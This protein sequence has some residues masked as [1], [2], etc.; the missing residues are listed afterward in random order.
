MTRLG[1]TFAVVVPSQSID[2]HPLW[3][4]DGRFIFANVNP[5][6]WW[7]VDLSSVVLDRATYRGR[8]V[9]ALA[10]GSSVAEARLEEVTQAK[11]V[12]PE[13][14]GDLRLA[15]GTQLSWGS[16]GTFGSRLSIQSPFTAPESVWE[17]DM[18]VCGYLIVSPDR[19]FVATY[20]E[21]TGVIVLRI[22]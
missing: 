21:L 18:A 2:D 9:G 10:N 1:V 6:G 22:K 14:K 7:K 19:N 8:I 4:S 12:S 11:A 3:S 5:R 13:V 16:R 15:D 20:C 17:T